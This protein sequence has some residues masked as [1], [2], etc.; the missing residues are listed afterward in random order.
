MPFQVV[1]STY[2]NVAGVVFSISAGP[3]VQVGCAT[4]VTLTASFVGDDTGHRF[5]WEQIEGTPVTWITPTDQLTVT[6]TVGT[7]DNKKF[8]F[9][10]DKGSFSQLF[11]DVNVWSSPV[12]EFSCETIPVRPSPASVTDATGSMRL[13]LNLPTTPWSSTDTGADY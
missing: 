2:K 7:Y 5:E 6:F 12:S 9:W 13:T 1:Y 11:D 3:D 4:E 8:R 10:M